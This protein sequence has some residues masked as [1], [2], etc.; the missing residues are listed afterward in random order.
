MDVHIDSAKR[1][2]GVLRVPGDKSIAHRALLC[3]ALANGWTRITG[4][5]RGAADLA[6]TTRALQTLG[7]QTQ[8]NDDVVIVEGGGRQMWSTGAETIDCANSGT[9]MRLLMGALATHPA[10]IRLVGDPSLSQRPMGRVAEPLRSMGANVALRDD[11]FAPLE[12]TGSATLDP[13]DYEL[14][15]ASAQLKSALIFAALGARGD[16]RLRGALNSRDHTERMLPSFGAQ[17][18]VS[19]DE[20]VVHG[21]TRLRGIF[22]EVKWVVV[23]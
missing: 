5:A 13:I 18:S 17:L 12:I 15:V 21:G 22:V 11:G 9:T 14:P 4:V 19:D 23:T 6:A 2:Q 7:V 8:R 16:T 1:L 10:T 20:I 3:G